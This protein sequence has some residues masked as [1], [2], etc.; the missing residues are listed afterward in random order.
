MPLQV[1]ILNQINGLCFLSLLFVY[2]TQFKRQLSTVCAQLCFGQRA[3]L[4]LHK[5]LSPQPPFSGD[6]KCPGLLT[7]DGP[8]D[9]LQVVRW[10]ARGC[11]V[12]A[13]PSMTWC[14]RKNVVLSFQKPLSFQPSP[15][16]SIAPL[17]PSLLTLNPQAH[18]GHLYVI[19]FGFCFCFVTSWGRESVTGERGEEGK[20][21][22]QWQQL[23]DVCVLPRKIVFLQRESPWAGKGARPV[24]LQSQPW[25]LS[26]VMWGNQQSLP[27]IRDPSV[28][29]GLN[30]NQLFKT[31]IVIKLSS[32]FL[33][34]II[35]VR[36]LIFN[37]YY[38]FI[39]HEKFGQV[40]HLN[41]VFYTCIWNL[42]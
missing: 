30:V 6:N 37:F 42:S 38:Q 8:H 4:S 16:T 41:V 22:F 34:V 25:S 1:F 2:A 26:K 24:W 33:G 29:I 28:I 27:A 17:L 35:S 18:I 7:A 40:Y 32:S 39:V 36:I 3:G 21:L 19:S 9:R 31:W 11:S 13:F 15:P 14:S 20:Q 12:P 10:R 5:I 23:L